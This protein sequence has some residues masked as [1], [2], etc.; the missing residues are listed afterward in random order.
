MMDRLKERFSDVS[1]L[2]AIV[3]C[4]LLIVLV[5]KDNQ[6]H[7]LVQRIVATHQEQ[8]PVQILGRHDGV[9]HRLVPQT[10]DKR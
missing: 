2:L 1:W 10:P 6:Y 4:V 7:D 8:A 3:I 9:A 5:I